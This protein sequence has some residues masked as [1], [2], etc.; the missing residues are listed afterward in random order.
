MLPHMDLSKDFQNWLLRL[1]YGDFQ[2]PDLHP[3]LVPASVLK[4]AKEY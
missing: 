1:L 2:H 4:E 3:D